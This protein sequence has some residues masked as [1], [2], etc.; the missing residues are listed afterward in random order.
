ME[1]YIDNRQGT[2]E[3]SDEIQE[4]IEK[5]IKESLL[6]EGKSLEYEVSVSL[7]S[8]EEIRGLN[9]DY[10]GIDSPTD[11]LS[12]PIEDRFNLGL[13]LLGDIIISV[14]K[15]LDQSEDFGHSIERELAYLTAHSMFHLM[16]YDHM[17]DADKEVMREKE[18]LVM[19]RLGIFKVDKGE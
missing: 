11:V 6:V 13:S 12:F 9:R 10:R 1:I 8:N 2:I 4:L 17:E 18:K 15:A 16:G 14:E 3:I 19:N 5:V 7:V